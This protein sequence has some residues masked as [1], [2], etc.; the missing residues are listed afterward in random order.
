[1]TIDDMRLLP[2]HLAALQQLVN[3]CPSPE[4]KKELIVMAG[5]CEAITREEAFTILTANQL[6]TA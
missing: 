1:V 5:A 2:E 3:R 4:A 6:E